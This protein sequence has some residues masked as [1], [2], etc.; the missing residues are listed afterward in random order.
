MGP[1]GQSMDVVVPRI[2]LVIHKSVLLY[3]LKTFGISSS[4]WEPPSG[5]SGK[6]LIVN[7]TPSDVP[8]SRFISCQFCVALCSSHCVSLPRSTGLPKVKS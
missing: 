3:C 7:G 5:L 6:R 4:H 8:P 1:N 2:V